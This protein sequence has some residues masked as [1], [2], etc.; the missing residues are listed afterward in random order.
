MDL[1]IQAFLR[2]GSY[3]M[4]TYFVYSLF[5][6]NRRI[7]FIIYAVLFISTLISLVQVFEYGLTAI[8]YVTL[9]EL[10]PLLL[11]LYAFLSITGGISVNIRL[12]SKKLKSISS[13]I[14]TKYLLKLIFIGLIISSLLFGLGSYYFLEDFMKWVIISLSVV[15]LIASIYLFFNQNQIENEYVLLIVGRDSKKFYTYQIPPKKTKILVKDFY[16]NETY[17]VDPIGKITWIMANKKIEI[18]YLYWIA[19]NDQI[20]MTAEKALT[21]VKPEFIDYI[22]KFEKYHYRLM[23]LSIDDKSRIELK[24]QRLIK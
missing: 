17:I 7:S 4:I 8:L 24:S 15:I 11:A 10:L 20:D 2:F 18:H 13:D 22:E 23:T 6:R 14:Q 21:P 19:T 3:F 16:Q 5:G 1:I 12:K 9:L